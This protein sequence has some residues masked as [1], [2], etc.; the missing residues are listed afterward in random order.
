MVLVLLR[1]DLRSGLSLPGRAV[2]G[3]A[4]VAYKLPSEEAKEAKFN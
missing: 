1:P 2:G 3:G 4:G